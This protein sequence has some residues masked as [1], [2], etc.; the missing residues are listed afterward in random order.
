MRYPFTV[1]FLMM[2]FGYTF[3]ILLGADGRPFEFLMGF[4]LAVMLMELN[5]KEKRKKKR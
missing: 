3:L 1:F 5:G 4:T 2:F